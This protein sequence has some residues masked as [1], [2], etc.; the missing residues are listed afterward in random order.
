MSLVGHVGEYVEGKEDI[1]SYIE[2]VELYFAANYVE[3]DHKVSTFLLLNGADAYGVLRNMLAQ[4]PLKVT[5]CDCLVCGLENVQIQKKLLAER[6]LNFK[7][8][9]E[10]VQS[11]E[12][13]KKEDFCDVSSPQDESVN[14]VS[15]FNNEKP[16]NV[17]GG[18]FRCGQHHQQQP[19]VCRFRAVQCFK[20]Q[21]KGH[22]AKMC[23]FQK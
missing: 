8:A 6:D 3:M 15:K 4:N 9:F 17:R 19:M 1:A 2:R 20:C 13:A 10:T 11:M 5:F 12:M 16:S 7:K 21:R 14:K 18:C 22:V 23:S